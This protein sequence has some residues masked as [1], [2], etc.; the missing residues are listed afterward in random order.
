MSWSVS[1][2]ISGWEDNKGVVTAGQ[3]QTTD[4]NRRINHSLR[5]I[6]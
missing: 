4:R 5:V 3:G 2:G 6:C 1:I